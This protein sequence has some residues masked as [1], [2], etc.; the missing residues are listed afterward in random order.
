MLLSVDLFL[1]SSTT[2]L[3][4]Q[5]WTSFF[6]PFSSECSYLQTA[7]G[8]DLG[9]GGL[10]IGGAVLNSSLS[11]ICGSVPREKA[12]IFQVFP[13]FFGECCFCLVSLTHFCRESFGD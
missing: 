7:N 13:F 2:S 9:G 5:V 12:G 6:F 8:F 1:K 11:A 3:L 4:L 10:E